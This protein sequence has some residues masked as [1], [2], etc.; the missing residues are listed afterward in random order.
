MTDGSRRCATVAAAIAGLLLT[1]CTGTRIKRLSGPAFLKQAEQT[2]QVGSFVWTSYIGSTQQ[3]AY[4]EYG[5]PAFIGG[6]MQT[7]VYWTPLSELPTN[8]VAQ[9]KT[10][11]RPWTNWM[12]R[13]GQ[14]HKGTAP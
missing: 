1:G 2:E 6:G 3:K 12:D 7:T 11:T 8:I 5:H 4:L 13:V 14:D 10:G 9:I